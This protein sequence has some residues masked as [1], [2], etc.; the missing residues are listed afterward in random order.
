MAAGAI[1]EMIK[2][3]SISASSSPI[4]SKFKNVLVFDHSKCKNVRVLTQNDREKVKK[5]LLQI[6]M[7]F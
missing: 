6:T 5:V 7:G 4:A 3:Q 2:I 1:L